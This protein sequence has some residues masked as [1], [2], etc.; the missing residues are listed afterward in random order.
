MIRLKENVAPLLR[1]ASIALFV[2][3]FALLLS[4]GF[5]RNEIFK[6]LYNE[7]TQLSA[8]TFLLFIVSFSGICISYTY[9]ALLTANGNLKQLNFMAAA[10]VVISIILNLILVPRF[11][12]IGAAATNAITQ[13]F[14]V[15]FHIVVVKQKFKFKT[16]WILI[17]KLLL[18]LLFIL[19]TG[20]SISV[21]HIYWI[22]GMLLITF[23]S[24]VFAFL[25]KLINVSVFGQLLS[26]KNLE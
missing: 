20:Y 7:H 11:K 6:L 8:D 10:A 23:V 15:V 24:L 19:V 25:I 3:S 5:Y 18:F 2:P 14:T 1:L 9:G 21:T 16:N 17:L 22:I 12:V 26:S 4:A 13:L